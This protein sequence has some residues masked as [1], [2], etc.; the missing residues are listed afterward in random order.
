MAKTSSTDEVVELYE[1]SADSYAKTM[2]AEIELPIYHEVLSRLAE[3]IASLNGPVVDTSCGSGHML[4]RYHER[5]DSSRELIGVDLSPSMVG[6]TQKTMGDAATIRV[7]DM[8]VLPFVESGT[9]AAVISFFSLHHLSEDQVEATL[10]EWARMLRPGGRLVL[11]AWEGEGPIDYGSHSDVVAFQYTEQQVTEWAT[12]AGL[13][14]ESHRVEAI[15][16]MG[17]RAVYL[18]AGAV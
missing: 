4:Q 13:V 17:M 3:R 16:D 8:R 14:V 7:G 9:A 12:A 6:I 18:E 11:A 2:D 10:G 15:E 1:S 5:Y